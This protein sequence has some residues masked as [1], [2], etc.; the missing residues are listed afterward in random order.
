M[1]TLTEITKEAERLFPCDE[2]NILISCLHILELREAY[3]KGYLDCQK[4]VNQL[5]TV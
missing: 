4:K 1:K 5:E 2:N 3:I